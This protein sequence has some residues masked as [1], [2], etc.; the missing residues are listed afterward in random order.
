MRTRNEVLLEILQRG[1]LNARLA[2]RHGNAEQAWLECDHI[3]NLISAVQSNDER[4]FN[5]YWS[6]E[7]PVYTDACKN[8]QFKSAFFGLW[9]ELEEVPRPQQQ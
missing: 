7:R 2:A 8:L 4:W 5:Q 6:V 9:A 1:I 3:H